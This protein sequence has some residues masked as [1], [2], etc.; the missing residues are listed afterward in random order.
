[1][2][3]QDMS[4]ALLALGSKYTPEQTRV[5][6]STLEREA[7]DLLN[8][9]RYQA[10]NFAKSQLTD[11]GVIKPDGLEKFL[12]ANRG[13]L[14]AL[15]SGDYVA[16]LDLLSRHIT[17]QA[18]ASRATMPGEE[19]SPGM[20]VFRSLFGPLSPIQRRLTA[21]ARLISGLEASNAR[22]IPNL[23]NFIE[24]PEKMRRYLLAA[25]QKPGTVRRLQAVVAL[26]GDVSELGERDQELYRLILQRNP[27]FAAEQLY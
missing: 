6:V 23:M 1:M 11:N 5:L 4:R 27:N 12:T 2:S 17:K 20:Q 9:L 7:P 8:S 19:Q 24:D 22:A 21:G 26:G 13:R 10:A 15:F 25:Q 3:G 18:R 14:T 16:G